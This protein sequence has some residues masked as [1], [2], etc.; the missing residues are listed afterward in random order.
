[1]RLNL[2]PLIRNKDSG[3]EKPQCE[4]EKTKFI[5]KSSHQAPFFPHIKCDSTALQLN[6]IP[7]TIKFLYSFLHNR[8][9]IIHITQTSIIKTTWIFFLISAKLNCVFISK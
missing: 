5:Q 8:S 3:E 9:I 4:P 2:G 6:I 1:M 7:K